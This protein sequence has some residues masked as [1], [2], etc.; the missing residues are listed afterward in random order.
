MCLTAYNQ[1]F[2]WSENTFSIDGGA[3]FP[4]VWR[5]THSTLFQSHA[6]A[7]T[8]FCSHLFTYHFANHYFWIEW[9]I[10]FFDVYVGVCHC[11]YFSVF[12]WFP[13]SP[14]F[15]S[16]FRPTT[17]FSFQ[18]HVIV[19]AI[20]TCTLVGHDWSRLTGGYNDWLRKR[21]V[22]LLA[23]DFPLMSCG[24]HIFTSIFNFTS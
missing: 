6:T 9:I 16:F 17:L 24:G 10:T 14:L 15:C 22:D 2:K 20:L 1:Y 21:M 19:I 13:L 23:N 18:F 11:V 5:R 3:H 4:L 12:C 8:L 7:K